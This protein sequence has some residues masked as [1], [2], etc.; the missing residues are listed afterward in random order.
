MLM[1]N[2]LFTRA[3]RFAVV[4]IGP[5]LTRLNIQAKRAP[6]ISYSNVGNK[7]F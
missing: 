7:K 6:G 2:S 5:Y 4:S 3:A 1:D